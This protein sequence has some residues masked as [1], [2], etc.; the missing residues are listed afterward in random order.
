M[1]KTT[2]LIGATAT[3]A[4][5]TAA[6]AQDST[7]TTPNTETLDTVAVDHFASSDIDASGSLDRDEFAAFVARHAE[8][9]DDVY[10]QLTET[11]D[12]DIAFMTR[13]TNA[14][15][16][17]DTDELATP[18]ATGTGHLDAEP[19]MEDPVMEDGTFGDPEG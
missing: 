19:V 3:L 9:G 12:Y 6:C 15:G 16:V 14:D 7:Y 18:A 11:G 5:A 17:L 8:D 2:A 10:I 1:L 4:I 13:D